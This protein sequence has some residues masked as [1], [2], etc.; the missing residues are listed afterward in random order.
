MK[1]NPIYP[2]VKFEDVPIGG[3]FW[4]MDEF[5]IKVRTV[6]NFNAIST[7]GDHFCNFVD[8]E[9]VTYYPNASLNLV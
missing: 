3:I 6:S 5:F 9:E 2:D 7:D 8:D 4:Y 1:I